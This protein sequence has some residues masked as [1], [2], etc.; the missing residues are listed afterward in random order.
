MSKT[1]GLIP[2][3]KKSG[4]RRPAPP[5]PEQIKASSDSKQ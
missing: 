1:I 2:K 5:Q 3:I 4:S